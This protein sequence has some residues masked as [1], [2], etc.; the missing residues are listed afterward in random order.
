MQRGG[1]TY[2][3]TGGL[4]AVDRLID[5]KGEDAGNKATRFRTHIHTIMSG[6]DRNAMRVAS[7][8]LRHLVKSSGPLASTIVD[9]EEKAA[10]ESLQVERNEDRRFAAV[11]TLTE[12]AKSS[13]TL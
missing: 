2:E 8:V 11:L 9:A 7:A 1:N 4:Y 6:S 5:F 13:P 3:R 10:L 12:L